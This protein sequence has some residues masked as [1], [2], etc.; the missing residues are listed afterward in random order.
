M[1]RL[2]LCVGAALLAIVGLFGVLF[3]GGLVA[4]FVSTYHQ[5]PGVTVVRYTCT[6]AGCPQP[7]KTAPSSSAP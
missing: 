4:G 5:S 1:K 3:V 6:G 7:Q 2:L